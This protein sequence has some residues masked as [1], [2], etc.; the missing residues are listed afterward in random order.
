MDWINYKVNKEKIKCPVCSA[1]INGASGQ[2]APKEGDLSV[3]IYCCTALEF[4]GKMGAMQL[5]EI[6]PET[7]KDLKENWPHEFIN[8]NILIETARDNLK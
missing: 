4:T 7:M 5:I 6:R 8:L 3:C 1:V 2:T